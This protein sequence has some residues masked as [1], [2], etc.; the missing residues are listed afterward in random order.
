MSFISYTDFQNVSKLTQFT[1]ECYSARTL[2]GEDRLL[3]FPEFS[4]NLSNEQLLDIS[5]RLI[6]YDHPALAKIYGMTLRDDDR[7]GIVSEYLAQGSLDKV[8]ASI[9]SG[10]PGKWNNTK[11]LTALYGIANALSFLDQNSESIPYFDLTNIFLDEKLYPHIG[12]IGFN[13]TPDYNRE[14]LFNAPELEDGD[15]GSSSPVF[16]FGSVTFF[17]LAK[18]ANPDYTTPIPDLEAYSNEIPKDFIE[19]ISDCWSD[20][21]NRPSF[22]IILSTL[23]DIKNSLDDVDISEFNAY[24][25]TLPRLGDDSSIND[26]EIDNIAGNP[27]D[28]AAAAVAIGAA[29]TAVGDVA[30]SGNTP[31]QQPQYDQYQQYQQNQQYQQYQQY[32]E[33]QAAYQA[34]TC[35]QPEQLSQEDGS[36]DYKKLALDGDA[37]AMCHLARKYRFGT[38]P[39]YPK[40]LHKALYYYKQGSKQRYP[41]AMNGYAEMLLSGEGSTPNFKKAARYYRHSAHEYDVT[42]SR[43]YAYLLDHGLGVPCDH[44]EANKYFMFAASKGDYLASYYYGLNMLKG[45][46]C[47]ANESEAQRWIYPA[48]Q[49]NIPAALNTYGFMLEKGMGLVKDEKQAFTYYERAAATGNDNGKLNCAI[50][51]YL[52]RGT[53]KDLSKARAL[54]Q[55]LADK[56]NPDGLN[57]L[58]RLC[59]TSQPKEIDTAI[60]CYQKLVEQQDINGYV[61]LGLL[62]M[63]DQDKKHQRN[64][65]AAEKLFKAASNAG[66]L[67]GMYEYA[68]LKEYG[69]DGVKKDPTEAI[70]LH[71]KAADLGYSPA[72][73]RFAYCCVNGIGCKANKASMEEA[74]PYLQKAADKGNKKAASLLQ[75]VRK[76]LKI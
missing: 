66:S 52:G 28:S 72:Q 32:Q 8:S 70:T 10:N 14:S 68:K 37:S 49:Q 62:Y 27:V 46:G 39:A 16:I 42:A 35:Q 5:A 55:E 59:E 33:Q 36:T 11:T 43:Q 30:Y 47:E 45:I 25:R 4:P 71:R 38:D 41:E 19:L 53:Q 7:V 74:L 75:Q 15:I 22:D 44:K 18:T 29:A 56:G 65:A 20:P 6:D 54:F 2:N 48:A 50:M 12:S 24:V 34:I 21:S 63:K 1:I 64:P 58:A 9:R 17:L 40:N 26:E 60:Q 67:R 13:S 76:K 73:Y 23:L 61:N 51:Y 57:N 69:D 31:S 3:I